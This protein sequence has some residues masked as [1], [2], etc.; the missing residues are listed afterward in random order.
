MLT[1]SLS[2][3]YLALI[4]PL[5]LLQ[6]TLP[7]APS[8][9]KLVLLLQ[10]YLLTWVLLV[11]ATVQVHEHA[12]GGVYW[13]TAW[14]LA[15]WL[16]LGAALSEG[17]V[18]AW[19]SGPEEGRKAALDLSVE[20]DFDVTGGSGR[21][22]VRGVRYDAPGGEDGEGENGG[23]VETEPTEITP[24]M[25]QQRGSPEIASEAAKYDEYGW[26]ILQMVLAVPVV[27]TLLFQLQ[28]LLLQALM[29]TLA[30]GSSALTGEQFCE[31]H[32]CAAMTDARFWM[33]ALVYASLSVL[34]LLIFLPV[35]PFAH[36]LHHWLTFVVLVV[37]A[38]TL[39]AS[40]T[41]FPFSQERPYKVFFQQQVEIRNPSI[42]ESN[43]SPFALTNQDADTTAVLQDSAGSSESGIR[44][45]TTL[46]G[47]SSYLNNRIITELPSSWGKD[48]HCI[49]SSFRPGLT[50]CKWESDLVPSPGGN[51]SDGDEARWLDVKT[52]RLNET[53]GMVFVRGTNTRGCR[54]Y[55]DKPI[56][57]Y[58]LHD[59]KSDFSGTNASAA[60]ATGDLLPGYEV[61]EGGVKEVR[62]WSREWERGFLVEVGWASGSDDALAEEPFTG[63][64]AC[65]WAEYAS[66]SEGGSSPAGRTGLIPALEE[67]KAFLPLWAQPTKLTDGLVEAR[68]KFA[69]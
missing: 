43:R 7:T 51:S 25:H 33:T 48:I 11:A 54:L 20:G 62:L 27:V 6:L 45:W 19:K 3:A 10:H 65:E 64:A 37:F 5:Q 13:V 39:I 4:V 15:A 28:N 40:W 31:V 38:L 16:A 53:H 29:N 41:F 58:K 14:N 56:Q 68:T 8:A 50:E 63:Q 1:T 21:R 9:Q 2:L 49:P 44:V 61:P 35:T 36:R 59:I 17:A 66:A 60:S 67:V 30:D 23:E 18:R 22:L 34:S 52:M 24:L 55:F 42:G 57:Y 32:L 69:L 47:V 46:T 26:W 12:L